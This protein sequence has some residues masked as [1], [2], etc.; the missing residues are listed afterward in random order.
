MQQAAGPK[1]LLQNPSQ[2]EEP[3]ERRADFPP[4]SGQAK[5]QRYIQE[6]SGKRRGPGEPGPYTRTGK[7]KGPEPKFGAFVILSRRRPTFPHSYP[8]SIIGPARL[9][10]RVRDGNGCDPRGMT[11]GNLEKLSVF[12]SRFSFLK[13][14]EPGEL[15]KL[16]EKISA[17]PQGRRGQQ[18][19][20]A[21]TSSARCRTI[22][23]CYKTLQFGLE[24][25]LQ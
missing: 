5:D 8:C 24:T 20:L 12:D 7:E 9:N 4:P 2:T 14:L 18:S 23:V 3:L 17:A 6:W 25:T 15:R 21:N 10:F 22:T 13:K 19:W 11:T 1:N 16:S